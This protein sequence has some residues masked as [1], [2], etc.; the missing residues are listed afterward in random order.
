MYGNKL[1]RENGGRTEAGATDYLALA[2]VVAV[3]G[4][5]AALHNMQRTRGAEA[6]FQPE[7]LVHN[8][9]GPSDGTEMQFK[10]MEAMVGQLPFAGK[11]IK[12]QMSESTPHLGSCLLPSPS[13]CS[14]SGGVRLQPLLR[15]S[16]RGRSNIPA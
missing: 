5:I 7:L 9:A 10:G 11:K 8:M 2:E 14:R 6:A 15:R 12:M 3:E 1:E 4:Q 13:R 16:Q